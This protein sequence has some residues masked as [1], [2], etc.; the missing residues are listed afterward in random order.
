MNARVV[1]ASGARLRHTSIWTNTT[2]YETRGTP[3]LSERCR[4]GHVLETLGRRMTAT[5]I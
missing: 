5:I 3:A 4:D 1:T 2:T